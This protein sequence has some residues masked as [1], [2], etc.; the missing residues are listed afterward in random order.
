M[1]SD[2]EI[3]E[4]EREFEKLFDLTL[5]DGDDKPRDGVSAD[6]EPSAPV[7]DAEFEQLTKRAKRD[8]RRNGAKTQKFPLEGATH[9]ESSSDTAAVTAEKRTTRS[10]REEDISDYDNVTDTRDDVISTSRDL[11]T[12]DVIEESPGATNRT[13]LKDQR[14]ERKR[15][16]N[17]AK[18]APVDI[19]AIKQAMLVGPVTSSSSGT[20]S[21]AT[22]SS[23]ETSSSRSS[24][25]RHVT[26]SV[27]SLLTRQSHVDVSDGDKIVDVMMEIREQQEREGDEA[28]DDLTK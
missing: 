22:S 5:D 19:E 18:T 14:A 28:Q 20:T 13:S 11:P 15:K 8:A 4:V 21:G 24:V 25:E 12:D 23:G 16:R 6:R 17:R 27:T 1:L 9:T 7:H 10:R 26:E 3:E 2:K